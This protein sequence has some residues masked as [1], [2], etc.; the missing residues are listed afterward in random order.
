M[1]ASKPNSEYFDMKST[2]P[3]PYSRCKVSLRT[4]A[5]APKPRYVKDL[6]AILALLFCQ[7]SPAADSKAI[8]H[9]GIVQS[10]FALGSLGPSEKICSDGRMAGPRPETL[11]AAVIRTRVGKSF[12]DQAFEVPDEVTLSVG[13]TV[14]LKQGSCVLRLKSRL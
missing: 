4:H 5:F 14:E 1:S 13:D 6:A 10:V 8:W 3:S 7:A 9:E 11:R 12:Y 2:A